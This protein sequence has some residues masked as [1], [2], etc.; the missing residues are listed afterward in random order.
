LELQ[1]IISSHTSDRDN[2]SVAYGNEEYLAA[3]YDERTA[4]DIYGSVGFWRTSIYLP[5]IRK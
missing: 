5:L 2:P 3:W 4:H 1:F